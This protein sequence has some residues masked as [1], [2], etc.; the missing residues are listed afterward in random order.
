[1]NFNRGKSDDP[2]RT[3]TRKRKVMDYVVM[4]RETNEQSL[5]I[6]QLQPH[7][8]NTVV[9]GLVIN[10]QSVQ[11][12][13]DKRNPGSTRYKMTFSI[14]D[15]PTEY[16]NVTCW[17]SKAYISG[18]SQMFK[19]YD[20]VKIYNCQVSSKPGGELDDKWSPWTP[21]PYQ[22]SINET[23]SSVSIYNG[24]NMSQLLQLAHV[25]L[26]PYNDYYTLND[27]HVNGQ[28]LDCCHV[29]ILAIVGHVGI[30]KEMTS[31]SG[32]YLKKCDVILF[33]QGCNNFEF[34]IWDSEMIDLA[35]TWIPK[36]NI[37]F[38]VDVKATFNSYKNSMTGVHT[39]KTIIT[40]NP[41]CPQAHQ[42]YQYAQ[43]TDI[44]FSS[45]SNNIS[46]SVD[47]EMLP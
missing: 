17:G 25:P 31:K 36:E 40:T 44:D 43:T 47:C 26:R 8:S 22:L 10:K 2:L 46:Q 41:D 11:S 28:S 5:S 13:P 35:Q 9:I 34:T 14:R 27:I 16:I 23:Y 19:M 1:M 33:D 7:L 20:V 6:N 12:F 32:R 39:N 37:I 45:Y 30:P 38:V 29:N 18:I 21:S 42:L 4:E 24:E 15:T 3:T